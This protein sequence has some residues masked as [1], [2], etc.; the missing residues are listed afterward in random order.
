MSC[1]KHEKCYC[2]AI[3]S[4]SIITISIAKHEEIYRGDVK[5]NEE[6]KLGTKKTSHKNEP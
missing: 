4:E 1:W 2:Q 3:T 6:G 5:W